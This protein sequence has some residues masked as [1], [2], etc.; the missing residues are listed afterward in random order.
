MPHNACLHEY[1]EINTLV[2]NKLWEETRELYKIIFLVSNVGWLDIS[3]DTPAIVTST[4]DAKAETEPGS[5]G[6]RHRF[7]FDKPMMRGQAT[8]LSFTMKP[9]TT[10]ANPN[11]LVL[12]EETRAF[13]EPTVKAK[14]TVGF[15]GQESSTVPTQI[16]QYDHLAMYERPGEPLRGQLLKFDHNKN[17]SSV[18]ADF[19]D[20]Y[21]GMYS[22][23]AWKWQST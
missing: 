14:I 7:H 22:G 8:T 2:E 19:T 20:I 23:I 12:I 18:V 21:G 10:L 1:V 9:D 6:L 4:C 5:N 15:M 16:W 13:Y 17:I 3:S 11:D